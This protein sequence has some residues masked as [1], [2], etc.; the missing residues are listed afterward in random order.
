MHFG[1]GEFA[2]AMAPCALAPLGAAAVPAA[3]LVASG[4]TLGI[5]AMAL[6][7]LGSAIGW[8]AALRLARHPLD[9]EVRL[10]VAKLGAMLARRRSA[11]AGG[12]VE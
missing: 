1:W 3:L 5:A 11:P 2:G 12:Q 6:A 4:G 7:I 9:P 10:V 8:L